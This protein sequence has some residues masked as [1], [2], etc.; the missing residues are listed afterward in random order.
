MSFQELARLNIALMMTKTITATRAI[1]RTAASIDPNISAATKTATAATAMASPIMS[2][3]KR[4][5]KVKGGDVPG[6]PAGGR[7][8]ITICILRFIA[9]LL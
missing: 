5:Q 1:Q 6:G 7:E 4:C 9:S 8:E 3:L 2:S